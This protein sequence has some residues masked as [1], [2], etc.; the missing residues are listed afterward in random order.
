MNRELVINVTSTE[1]NIALCEDKVLA[2][3]NREV[4]HT[5][6]AVGDISYPAESDESDN[7]GS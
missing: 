6:F 5:G 7:S 2:E 3:L 4:A 1:I